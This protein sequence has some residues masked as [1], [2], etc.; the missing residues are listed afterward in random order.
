MS[1]RPD[2]QMI[3]R[4]TAIKLIAVFCLIIISFISL[5]NIMILKG[6]KYQSL[7]SEQQLYDSFVTAPRGDIYDANMNLLATSST[8]WNLFVTPNGLN[9][10][11][12]KEKAEEIRSTIA[13]GLAEIIGE[14][15]EDIIE[16]TKE[17]DYYVLI[18]KR[19]GK[20]AAD[21]IREFISNNSKLELTKYIGL[22][23]TTKRY[24][25]NDSL[26][27]SVLGFVGDDNQGLAG[28]E[29]YYDTTLTGVAGRV[30]AAKNAKGTD[31]PFTYEKVEEAKQ[32]DSLVLTID[33]YIQYACEKY[34]DN[35]VE[36][37][38][39][40]E[41]GAAIAM[42]VNTGEI[43]GMAISGD[44]NP[45]EPFKLSAEDQAK[46]EAETDKE[47]KNE[48][49]A[50]L[51]SRQWRNKAISDTYEPG[52]VFKIFTAST[53]LEENLVNEKSTFTCN[54]RYVVSGTVYNCH[55][56]IGGH[57]IQTLMQAMSNSCNPA[58]IQVGQLI[59]PTLFSKYFKAFGLAEKTGIDL[60]GEAYPNY[61]KEEDMG[62]TE[63]ASESFGQT[64]HITPIQM[65]T[66]AAT[67]VNGGYLVK[68][69]V[70]SKIVDTN[71]NVVK[72]FS[73]DYKRQVI[74][75]ETSDKM[76]TFMEYVVQNGAKNG[77]VA[78]YRIGGK[79]GTSEK[80]A[81]MISSGQRGLYIGSYV[82]IAPIDNPQIAVFVMID[83]PMGGV[84]YGGQI[85]APAASKIMADILPYMGI[86]PQYSDEELEKLSVAVPDLNQKDIETAKQ[87]IQNMGLSYKTVG[88]GDKVIKQ[89]PEAGA[90]VYKGG[91]V[92]IY[93]EDVESDE[94]TVPDFTGQ[95]AA[96]ANNT[97]ASSEVNIEFSGLASSASSTADS[98]D[99]A[100]GTKVKKGQVIKVH[101]S[102][103]AQ[104]D[105]AD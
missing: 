99:I 24:Y 102:E 35:A 8:D 31:M 103:K 11:A 32:G 38:N 6:E 80:V 40:A 18:K 12:D 97:A 77:Q 3:I 104:S 52:S 10:S 5:V 81:E 25:P 85:S 30:V 21:K 86:E 100:A 16:Q 47:K 83:Q 26:A 101:F 93:T 88:N 15:E 94:T 7:A 60:P 69:H 61:H 48:I 44:F 22:D 37:F 91:T 74:S 28:L 29:S 63:L 79:T 84:Y 14:K 78:G 59:G 62:P 4:A 39:A 65:I 50:E 49:R 9:K 75:K 19:V 71:G 55:E 17:N 33:S 13:K 98:Q 46:V 67:T 56:N 89:L 20:E 66:L 73:N 72:T 87:I 1:A 51:L 53:A 27:S 41:R 42:D 43:K 96:E 45:N 54:H 57:G 70:V 64:F 23:E 82:G 95:S 76:R 90:S 58:F 68:P 105:I 2:R 34:L 36:Q 92:I